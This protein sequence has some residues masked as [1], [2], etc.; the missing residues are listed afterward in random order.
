M[1]EI[2]DSLAVA[3]ARKLIKEI[4]ERLRSQN[5]EVVLKALELKAYYIGQQL[6]A[7]SMNPF[8][9]I[10]HRYQDKLIEA[11]SSGRFTSARSKVLKSA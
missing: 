4:E 1:C 11:C 7:D 9:K 5:E 2:Q 3:F 6:S 8:K 10:E